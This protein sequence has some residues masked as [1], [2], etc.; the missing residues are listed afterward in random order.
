MYAERARTQVKE[1][2]VK[3]KNLS[4]HQKNLIRMAVLKE[5]EQI[6]AMNTQV[7]ENIAL[8]RDAQEAT[9]Q[10]EGFGNAGVI[11]GASVAVLGAA[12]ALIAIRGCK[13]QGD[14]FE[15]V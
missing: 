11:A 1:A 15:R 5:K 14:N 4:R 10:E 7:S 6:R 9:A 12:A 2:K 8:L 3:G 13:K